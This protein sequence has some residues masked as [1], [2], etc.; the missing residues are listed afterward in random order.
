MEAD[1]LV[2]EVEDSEAAA[3]EADSLAGH[4][5]ADSPA[6][7]V[8]AV[9]GRQQLMVVSSRSAFSVSPSCTDLKE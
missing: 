7:V 6:A 5:A 8:P 9:L 3:V 4:S 1:F 2:E